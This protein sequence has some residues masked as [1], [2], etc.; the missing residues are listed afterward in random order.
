LDSVPDELDGVTTGDAGVAA[1]GDD[2]QQGG[3][4]D[5]QARLQWRLE[6]VRVIK[7]GT[8]GR[9]VAALSDDTGQMD[10]GNVNTFLTTCR[11]FAS[12]ADIVD[13]L[14]KRSVAP[15]DCTSFRSTVTPLSTATLEYIYSELLLLLYYTRLTVFFPGQP[16][17]VSRC[18]KGKT[19]LDLNEARDYG[20]FRMQWHQLNDMQTI[21]TLL[22]IDNHA[23]ISSL[24]FTGRMLFP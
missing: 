2:H 13:Q 24:I 3:V 17:W 11:T 14:I 5:G 6:E 1:S 15:T 21:S 8:L 12:T 19:S 18:Q 4:V 9:L 23:N 10:V 22:K 20:V 7:Y 16:A